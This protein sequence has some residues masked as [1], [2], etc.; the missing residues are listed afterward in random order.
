MCKDD[1]LKG[2]TLG[3]SPKHTDSGKLYEEQEKF[4]SRLRAYTAI[5]SRLAQAQ[6]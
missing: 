6:A 5:H 3:L 4:F 1:T 2:V